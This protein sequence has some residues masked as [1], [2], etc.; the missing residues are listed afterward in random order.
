M[1]GLYRI[2]YLRL[3][4]PFMNVVLLLL[5]IPTVLTYDP[6]ALKPAATKCLT[7]DRAGHGQRVPVPADRRPAA[8]GAGTGS[9]RG[10]R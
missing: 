2:K 9:A 1:A 4:Q 5:T 10:L 6:K 3:A 7:L 8:A